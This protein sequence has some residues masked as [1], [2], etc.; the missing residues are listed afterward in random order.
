MSDANHLPL[1]EDVLVLDDSKYYVVVVLSTAYDDE[2]ASAF[3][4]RRDV[5]GQTCIG[6]C[7]LCI[8]GT[9]EARLNVIFD[10]NSNS[11]SLLIGYFDSRV[12]GVVHLWQQRRK[13]FSI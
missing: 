13:A 8:D 9:W 2:D 11:D 5:L 6:T 10:E 3:L 12:D 1:T 4:H 7:I